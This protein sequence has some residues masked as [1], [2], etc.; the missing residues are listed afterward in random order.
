[1]VSKG[2]WGNST[3]AT[4]RVCLGWVMPGGLAPRVGERTAMTTDGMS[5][6]DTRTN[7][8][9]MG[10]NAWATTVGSNAAD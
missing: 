10:Y 4:G 6:A 9:W 7:V 3:M 2:T 1:M 5:V 8:V